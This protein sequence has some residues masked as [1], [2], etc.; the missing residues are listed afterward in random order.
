MTTPPG[1]VVVGRSELKALKVR[2]C[3]S[4][5]SQNDRPL[6]VSLNESLKRGFLSQDREPMFVG[7][8]GTDL[9][10]NKQVSRDLRVFDAS[11]A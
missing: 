1:R 2:G 9:L 8:L 10:C 11:V 3:S 5:P 6:G 4:G 7:N